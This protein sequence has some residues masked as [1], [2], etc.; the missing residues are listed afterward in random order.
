MH[1]RWIASV[2]LTGFVGLSLSPPAVFA[3]GQPEGTVQP[4][5]TVQPSTFDVDKLPVNLQRISRDIQQTPTARE[6]RN[7]LGLRYLIQVIARTPSLLLFTKDD[8]LVN[9]PVPHS[10]PS[11]QEMIEQVTPEPFSAPAG[12]L[13][14]MW[15]CLMGEG[16]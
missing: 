16:K 6:Q 8:N 2:V 13:N 9:G 15:R 4:S 10:A 14:A 11:H 7:G 12:D 5:S 1:L 3:Q